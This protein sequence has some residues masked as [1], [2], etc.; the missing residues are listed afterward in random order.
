MKAAPVEFDVGELGHAI[1]GQEHVCDTL[2]RAE[3]GAV[4]VDVADLG[5]A[6][7]LAL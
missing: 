1:D 3:L 4:D 5:F 6:E 7:C 2:G